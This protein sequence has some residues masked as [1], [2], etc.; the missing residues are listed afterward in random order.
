MTRKIRVFVETSMTGSRIE[1][2]EECPDNWDD[3]SDEEQM[4]YLVEVA[5]NHLQNNTDYAAYVV[6]DGDD[7]E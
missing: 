4:A 1:S 7:N 2:D 3:M 5:E 6:E